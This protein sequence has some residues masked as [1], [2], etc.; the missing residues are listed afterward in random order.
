MSLFV[1][2]FDLNADSW[3]NLELVDRVSKLLMIISL[4]VIM[5][6]ILLYVLKISP[7]KIKF[8]L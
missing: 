8:E 4:A 1:L 2:Y 6:F 7:K 3:V 5:Y